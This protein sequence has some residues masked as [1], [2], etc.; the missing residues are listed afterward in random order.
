[1]TRSSI[2]Y[3]TL[4]EEKMKL[5]IRALE[6]EFSEA[7]VDLAYGQVIEGIASIVGRLTVWNS[8]LEC[9]EAI[10][11]IKYYVFEA[12][13]KEVSEIDPEGRY[14]KIRNFIN[15]NEQKIR[16]K[17][18]VSDTPLP[19]NMPAYLEEC[20][21]FAKEIVGVCLE[22]FMLE[23]EKMKEEDEID[24]RLELAKG[25]REKL[26]A[27][28]EYR[29]KDRMSFIAGLKEEN[30]VEGAASEILTGGE[31]SA[32]KVRRVRWS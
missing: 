9:L 4:C 25:N 21:Q 10:P 3:S 20:S 32:Q 16:G 19:S 23:I 5:R 29:K 18:E 27:A 8:A 17:F 31:R 28:S 30:N 13:D 14:E 7:Q 11:D 2:S 1:M 15:Q 12:S 6:A 26:S 24:A 22:Q